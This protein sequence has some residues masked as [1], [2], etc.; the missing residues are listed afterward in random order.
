MTNNLYK[1][2]CLIC[3]KN[4]NEEI[5]LFSFFK[6]NQKICFNCLNKFKII[7][8]SIIFNNIEIH[9]LYE[10]NSFMKTLIYTYKGCYDI[11]LK[12]VF[13]YQF[14]KQIKAKYK[15]YI[16][17]FPPSYKDDDLNRG[18]NHIEEIVKT[19]NM[20]YEKLFY[21]CINYKQSDQKYANRKDI[22]KII[23]IKDDVI[24]TNKKYLIIDDIF[25]SGS[26][27]KTIVDLLIK[28]HV[29]KEN[30]KAL[31]IAKTSQNVEL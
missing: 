14:Y 16:I 27:I 6:L 7:N 20:K 26:T 4:L 2:I 11:K 30:I 21:K 19:L 31:I 1:N 29:K 23:K 18:F 28:N 22:K 12:E 5:S 9:F 25:T 3:F 24:I 13:L 17:I 8:K 15:S 10:Y